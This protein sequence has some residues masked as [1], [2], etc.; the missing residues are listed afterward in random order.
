MGDYVDDLCPY[1]KFRHDTITPFRP[2]ICENALQVTRL[3]FL[4]LPSAYSQDP[5]TDFHDKYV[6]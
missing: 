1:A 4:V 3:V 5:C 6:K 2:Q